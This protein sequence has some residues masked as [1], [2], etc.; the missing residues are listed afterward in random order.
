MCDRVLVM[1]FGEIVGELS[2][3]ELSQERVLSMAL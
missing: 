3:E 2:R 1:K